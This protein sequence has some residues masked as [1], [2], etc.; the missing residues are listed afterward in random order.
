MMQRWENIGIKENGKWENREIEKQK[1]REAE[2]LAAF[3]RP[4]SVLEGKK[5]AK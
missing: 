2:N 5:K 4:V 3:D 1:N